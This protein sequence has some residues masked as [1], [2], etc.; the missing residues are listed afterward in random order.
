MIGLQVAPAGTEDPEEKPEV[1]HLTGGDPSLVT[2]NVRVSVKQLALQG[3][4]GVLT[5]SGCCFPCVHIPTMATLGLPMCC[6]SAQSWEEKSSR[7]TV[8]ESVYH[9]LEKM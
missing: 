8:M 9:Q 5:C 4:E 7:H 3:D 6:P 1:C 2:G